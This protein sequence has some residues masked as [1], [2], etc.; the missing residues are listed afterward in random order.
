M[1]TRRFLRNLRPQWQDYDGT[2]RSAE[3]PPGISPL[4]GAAREFPLSRFKRMAMFSSLFPSIVRTIRPV[5]FVSLSLLISSAALPAQTGQSI[6]PSRIVSTID[7]NSRV[8]LHGYVHPLANAT[9]DRGAAPDSQPLSRMHLVLKRSAAQEAALQQYIADAHAPGSPAYH[10]WLTPDQFGSKFGPSDQD[11]ATVE[12][13]LGAHGFSVTGVAPGK[14]VIEF[15]GSAG[16]LR[17]AFHAQIHK[18]EVNGGMH[19][20]AANEPDIPAALSPVVGG[21]VA[22]NNFNVKSHARVLGKASFDPKTG[23]AKPEWTINGGAG[24]PTIGG[25]NFAMT[26]G[27]FGVQYDLPNATLNSK[28]TG[29]TYDGTGQTIAII[30]ESNINIDLVN[31]FRTLFGLPANPPNIIIDGNDPGID[32]INNPDGPNYASSEAYL[33]V[34]WSGA[35]APKATVDLVIAADTALEGGLYLAAEHA[36]YSNIAPVISISFGDCEADMGSTNQF[37]EQVLWEQAAAQGITVTV[38]TGDNGSAGCDNPDAEEY[39][40]LGA[41]VSGFASTPYDVAVGGY[42][43]LLRQRLR[44]CD[45]RQSGHVLEHDRLQHTERLAADPHP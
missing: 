43:L 2:Q 31:Q 5:A 19:F 3:L 20:A 9:N 22:L 27:D 32:G 28:Y 41:N 33:D 10:Q 16:Q 44:E 12:S 1:K 25:V 4:I 37:I 38:S 18:Y 35:V 24:Y 14:Q 36:V 26:P 7:E 40:T 29:T 17:D 21:F 34:E 39:A 8:S 11:I 45:A 42:R 30:N 23:T 15:S 13:W 6:V